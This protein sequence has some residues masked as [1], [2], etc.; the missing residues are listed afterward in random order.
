MHYLLIY[1]VANTYLERRGEYRAE[2][3]D[4]ARQ[5]Y[6]KGEL[7]LGGALADPVDKAILLFSSDSPH[8]ARDFAANDPYVK[9]GLVTSWEVREWTTVVGR[10]PAVD[11]TGR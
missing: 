3:L 11:L 2:H 9:S 10:D 5:A 1:N 4:L 8:V 6:E 7:I